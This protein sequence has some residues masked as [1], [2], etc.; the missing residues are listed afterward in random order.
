MYKV[1][2]V[3]VTA[4]DFKNLFTLKKTLHLTKSPYQDF[5][6]HQ[7]PKSERLSILLCQEKKELS[8]NSKI[9]YHI[10]DQYV[11]E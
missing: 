9:L 8:R 11:T 5:Q 4:Y 10:L 7:L 2:M 3:H 1:C 6:D